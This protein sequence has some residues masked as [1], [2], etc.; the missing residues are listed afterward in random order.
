MTPKGEIRI[1]IKQIEKNFLASTLRGPNSSMFSSS[2]RIRM[3]NE[4]GTSKNKSKSGLND[5]KNMLLSDNNDN[6]SAT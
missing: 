2:E 3:K 1:R 6:R 5:S 4:K